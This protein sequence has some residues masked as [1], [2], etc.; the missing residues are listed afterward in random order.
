MQATVDVHQADFIEHPAQ[1]CALFRQ[2]AGIFAIALEV[3]QVDF[4][5][6]NIPVTA[7][8]EVASLRLQFQQ[9]RQEHIHEAE[10]RQLAFFAG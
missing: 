5:M 8:H 3:L 7:D 9:M 10:F 2:E 1:P 4:I 6:R